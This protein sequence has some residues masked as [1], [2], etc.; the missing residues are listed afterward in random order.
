MIYRLFIGC[1]TSKHQAPGGEGIYLCDFDGEALTL[2]DV[3]VA[4]DV[5]NPSWLAFSARRDVLYAAE[6]CSERSRI[7]AFRV[8]GSRLTLIRRITTEERNLCHLTLWPDGRFLTASSYSSG[9]LIT[10][11]LRED[12]APDSV[13]DRAAHEG[14]GPHPRMQKS[15]HVH[16]A[17]LFPDGQR[18]LVSDLGNDTLSVYSLDSGAGKLH[19]EQVIPLEPGEGPRHAAFSPDGRYVTVAAQLGN[20]FHVFP[21]TPAGLGPRI[22]TADMC[23]ADYN[24]PCEGAADVHYSADGSLLYGSNRGHNSIV[25]FR[26]HPDG[27]LTE[28]RWASCGGDGPRSFCLSRDER[29]LFIANQYS[30]NVIVKRLTPRGEIGETVAQKKIPQ[31][32]FVAEYPR[33]HT[34]A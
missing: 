31:A 6:E 26:V 11:S 4:T 22:Q 10:V 9:S 7:S 32:V 17:F 34:P 29:F 21:V 20:H 5:I 18:I 14:S 25:S 24:E 12:G 23:P 27:T 13:T 2:T 33:A 28:P 1:Y 8:E 3:S 15:A 16:S 30:G 19:P